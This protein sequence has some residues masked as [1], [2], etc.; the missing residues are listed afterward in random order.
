MLLM[1]TDKPDVLAQMISDVIQ[2]RTEIKYID[3]MVQNEYMWEISV[4]GGSEGGGINI[5]ATASLKKRTRTVEKEVKEGKGETEPVREYLGEVEIRWIH[6]KL[7]LDTIDDEFVDD[8]TLLKQVAV[9]R[10]MKSD[11]RRALEEI[12]ILE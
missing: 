6:V 11:L 7:R 1:P 3:P 8:E 9:A 12:S 5:L 2:R 10:E 4:Q